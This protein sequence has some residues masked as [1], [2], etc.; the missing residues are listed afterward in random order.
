MWLDCDVFAEHEAGDHYIVIGKVNDMSPPDWH[1]GGFPLLY[2]RGQYH[3]LRSV[4]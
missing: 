2:F 3:H 1:E 4:A